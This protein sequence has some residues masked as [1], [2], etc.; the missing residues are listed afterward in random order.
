MKTLE[1][2]RRELCEVKAEIAG[3]DYENERIHY[4]WVDGLL[5]A[6]EADEKDLRQRYWEARDNVNQNRAEDLDHESGFKEA[7]EFALEDKINPA[8]EWVR[9][10]NYEV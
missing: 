1:E 3:K 10:A 2:L 5:Y 8:P 9:K 6:M 4:G 7:M